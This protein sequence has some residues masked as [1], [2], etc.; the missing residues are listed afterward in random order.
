MVLRPCLYTTFSDDLVR[1]T[2]TNKEVSSK[3]ALYCF[4]THHV[5]DSIFT[6]FLYGLRYVFEATPIHRVDSSRYE[7]SR[8][9]YIT[10]K[11]NRWKMSNTLDVISIHMGRDYRVRD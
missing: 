3:S 8:V 2:L 4:S 9:H 5:H 11:S 6:I 7:S 1:Q 10:L